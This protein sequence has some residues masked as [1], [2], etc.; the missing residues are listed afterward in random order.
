MTWFITKNIGNIYIL[1]SAKITL[2]VAFYIGI[3][4]MTNSV[5]FKESLGFVA[6]KIKSL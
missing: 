5:I 2:V 4:W 3:L 1:F 6:R